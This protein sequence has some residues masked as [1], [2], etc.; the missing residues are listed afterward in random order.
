MILKY[1]SF[2]G[3][4]I[5][6]VIVLCL[7]IQTISSSPVFSNDDDSE[8]LDLYKEEEPTPRFFFGNN[9]SLILDTR[10]TLVLAALFGPLL[11]AIPILLALLSDQGGDEKPSNG[12]G[13]GSGYGGGHGGGGG[14]GGGG[15]GGYGYAR[16][17]AVGAEDNKLQ[18]NFR[19]RSAMEDYESLGKFFWCNLF[20]LFAR[21][22]LSILFFK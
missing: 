8:F 9:G 14:G 6:T 5:K 13:S 2:G 15:Y 4:L 12:Y 1:S 21:N 17:T 20:F 22:F 7:S 19:K 18:R 16:Q 10:T 11:A 3:I